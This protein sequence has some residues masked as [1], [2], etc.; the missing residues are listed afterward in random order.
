MGAGAGGSLEE[1]LAGSPASM[2]TIV[3]PQFGP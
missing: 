3:F 1:F 2:L